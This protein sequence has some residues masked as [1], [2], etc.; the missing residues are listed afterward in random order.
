MPDM[1]QLNLWEVILPVAEPALIA[2]V[3]DALRTLTADTGF[4]YDTVDTL[5]EDF[6]LSRQGLGFHWNPAT[7]AA[8]AADHIEITLPYD[9]LYWVFTDLGRTLTNDIGN[10]PHATSPR[11]QSARHR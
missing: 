3:N 6:F 10:S 9:R 8:G 1:H 7:I 5:P 2:L 11:R 4:P